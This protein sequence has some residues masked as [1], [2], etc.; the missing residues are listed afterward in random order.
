MANP[1][2]FMLGLGIIIGSI[3]LFAYISCMIETWKN[4]KRQATLKRTVDN[5]N[6]AT[7]GVRS[8]PLN[9]T[10]FTYSIPSDSTAFAVYTPTPG[11]VQWT[12][13]HGITEDQIMQET[14][15][16]LKGIQ[17]KAN[18]D[19]VKLKTRFEILKNM[20]P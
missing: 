12:S 20:C 2:L 11:I 7:D 4:K 13:S 18:K 16:L 1:K 19:P 6:S 14:A 15:P 5:F 3:I 17:E 8:D 10:S 9:Y